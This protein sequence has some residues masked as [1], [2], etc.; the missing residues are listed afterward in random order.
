MM[1][2]KRAMHYKLEESPYG[3]KLLFNEECE[4]GVPRV[5]GSGAIR[6]DPGR[7]QYSVKNFQT[8]ELHEDLTE[9]QVDGALTELGIANSLWH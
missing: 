4:Q 1:N 8:L 5:P 6:R 9:D 3:A 7:E 2:W